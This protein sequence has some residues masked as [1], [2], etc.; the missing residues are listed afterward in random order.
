MMTRKKSVLALPLISVRH[1]KSSNFVELDQLI[2]ISCD[3][4]IILMREGPILYSSGHFWT[5]MPCWS[6]Q[7][8]TQICPSGLIFTDNHVAWFRFGPKSKSIAKGLCCWS[9][10]ISVSCRASV[11][12]ILF[13]FGFVFSPLYNC[14]CSLISVV[15]LRFDFCGRCSLPVTQVSLRDC[16]MKRSGHCQAF[17]MWWDI[18]MD[19]DGEVILSCA[20]HWEHPDPKDKMQVIADL[21]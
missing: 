9:R 17:F 15:F 11:Y 21:C 8:H 14:A 7:N 5:E 1:R 13:Q 3:A 4:S 12:T 16:V 10:I 20:P 18:D 2:R 6:K 19:M